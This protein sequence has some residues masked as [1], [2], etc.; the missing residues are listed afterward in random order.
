M[1]VLKALLLA[2]LYGSFMGLVAY[3]VSLL[4]GRLRVS[5]GAA[6]ILWALV[7]LRLLCPVGITSAFSLFNAPQWA[8]QAAEQVGTRQEA[9]REEITP[10]E[11][12][13]PSQKPG[14]TANIENMTQEEVYQEL[15]IVEPGYLSSVLPQTVE[16]GT[17][18]NFGTV[19]LLVWLG[20]VAC[21]VS[22][23]IFSYVRFKR[24]LRLSSWLDL[25]LY[26]ADSVTTACV[27]G[28]FHPRIYLPTGLTEQQK[29]HTVTHE[30]CHIRRGDHIWKILSYGVLAAH[31]FNPLVWLFYL[32]F[33]QDMELACDEKALKI[34]GEG[35]KAAYSQS[36]L[37]LSQK[38]RC[39]TPGPV[40]FSENPTKNRILR[41]LRYKRPLAVVTALV[42]VV[43]I[44]LVGGV[45]A[46]PTEKEGLRLNEDGTVTVYLPT[47]RVKVD[48]KG[49]PVLEVD[50]KGN[51]AYFVDI[52]LYNADGRPVRCDLCDMDTREVIDE[53]NR[54]TY[55][56]QG[57]L[58]E[59]A[60]PKGKDSFEQRTSYHYNSKGNLSAVWR[61]EFL[62]RWDGIGWTEGHE[63]LVYR[64]EYVYDAQGR[65]LRY[66]AP[67][68]EAT[69]ALYGD[70]VEYAYREEDRC[71]EAQYYR[72]GGNGQK[73]KSYYAEM[74]YD[75]EGKLL[76]ID[77]QFGEGVGNAKMEYAYNENGD[78]ASATMKYG[79]DGKDIPDS[80]GTEFLYDQYGNVIKMLFYVNGE[81]VYSYEYH[82]SPV[83]VTPEAAYRLLHNRPADP[84]ELD[85]TPDPVYSNP[86]GNDTNP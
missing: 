44:L 16:K 28:I 84:F 21:F 14:T 83:N 76:F 10:T 41:A 85:P 69:N 5:R 67:S 12:Q 52:L 17:S 79:Y 40:G 63:E 68:I 23:G 7:A 70:L 72:T 64:E 19:I 3:G 86:F 37:D 43:G 33:Q 18:G 36:L 47:V 49:E 29:Y 55:D 77:M 30:K 56:E 8:E 54:Y 45:A 53:G 13:Q 22:W 4:V 58:I 71:V 32:R 73:E 50:E 48:A 61:Y 20:G 57:H 62:K 2:S 27:V 65:L 74:Y 31:W 34:L 46:Q 81:C 59:V 24:S 78:V 39:V 11:I 1:T 26:E 6:M 51:L 38:E 60:V 35:E 80:A 9:Q 15:G 82:T 42:L 75:Q 66:N 25:G